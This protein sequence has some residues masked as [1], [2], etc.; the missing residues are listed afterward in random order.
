MWYAQ[1]PRR[2]L[3]QMILDGGT[4]GERR[5]LSGDAV[6]AMT[7]DQIPGIPAVVLAMRKT[8][9]R[10]GYGYHFSGTEPWLRYMGG[11]VAPG[12]PHHGGAGGIA[13]WIDPATGIVAC[14]FEILTE[15]SRER[16]PV[17]WATHRFEDVV[18]AAV[19]D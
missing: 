19:L 11:T 1:T 12:S 2:R 7:T 4:V 15:N 9:A 14:Y 13:A 16:G 5:V 6:R 8:E 3:G 10:W 17:S 18:T